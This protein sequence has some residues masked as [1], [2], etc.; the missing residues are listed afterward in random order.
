MS[1]LVNVENG[2]ATTQ[3]VVPHEEWLTARKALVE[4]EKEF[5]KA[6]DEL[7][8]LRRALPMEAVEKKYVFQGH[9]GG[10][11]NASKEAGD[12]SMEDLFDGKSQLIVYHFMFRP[13]WE[14]G[15]KS[16]SYLADHFNPAV[17]HLAQRDVAMVAVSRAPLV[18]LDAFKKRM[19]WSFRW[20]SSEAN[21][22]NHDY[23]V[24]FTE[25]EKEQKKM[26]YNYR[27]GVFP[28]TEAPGISVFLRQDGKIYHT[29]STYA[30]G[31]D[32]FIN[33]YHLLDITPKGRD[34]KGFSY[35]MEWVRHHDRYGPADDG[36]K[37]AWEEEGVH[38]SLSE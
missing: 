21:E 34:E 12:V 10:A 26:F 14:D 35:P 16:C 1:E 13:D 19:G 30:R 18:K 3:V 29:Y 7:S 17:I 38:P 2:T 15:C 33:A 20:L 23:G 28:C 6:R 27:E 4:K 11:S 36:E 9:G 37:P 8:T 5:N 25:E 31:L 22:F 32:M 24:T